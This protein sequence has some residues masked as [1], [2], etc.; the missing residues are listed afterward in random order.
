[1]TVALV[2]AV[3]LDVI[4]DR[5][6]PNNMLSAEDAALISEGA[7]IYQEHC[8][9]CHGVALEGQ[10]NWR[11]KNADGRW[12]APPHDESGHTWHHG[13]VELFALT[14]YG[15][16]QLVGGGYESDM[17]G[18]DGVLTDHQITAVLSYIKSTWPLEIQVRQDDR[19]RAQ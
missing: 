8:A 16:A 10:P 2:V 9:V 6:Q 15:P 12:P 17:P 3:G 4:L 14:K 13:D 7:D 11:E 5:M 1:M 18:F 19:N